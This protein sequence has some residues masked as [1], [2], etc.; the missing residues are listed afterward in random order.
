MGSLRAFG[1]GPDQ[2]GSKQWQSQQK[3]PW[4]EVRRDTGKGKNCFKI[5]D[6][7]ADERCTRPVLDFL[8]TIV[9]GSRVGPR[10]VP[11][12]PVDGEAKGH[13]R[14]DESEEELEGERDANEG[15]E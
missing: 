3:T 11:P 5:R 14:K 15:E 10:T 12:E 13:G 1:T 4:A 9:V 7:L 8:H 2:A 6:L